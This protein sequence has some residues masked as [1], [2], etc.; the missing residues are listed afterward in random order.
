MGWPKNLSLGL[1]A[2]LALESS[3]VP[4]ANIA[5]ELKPA[6]NVLNK[7]SD[8]LS[9]YENNVPI[10]DLYDITI[11]LVKDS[12]NIKISADTISVRDSLFYS[13]LS[14][15]FFKREKNNSHKTYRIESANLNIK[16]SKK[17]ELG[18][19]SVCMSYNAGN[20]RI[21]MIADDPKSVK[22]SAEMIKNDPSFS[23]VYSVNGSKKA[24]CSCFSELMN[25]Q[26]E[27]III[28]S[29]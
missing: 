1:I 11:K 19:I 14:N 18:D 5:Q 20:D 16:D 12:S 4:A 6:Q 7:N 26:L 23:A 3:A 22:I 21:F 10:S 24:A 15:R 25:R 27:N 28:E 29:R 9:L 8:D 2:A 13:P 17:A